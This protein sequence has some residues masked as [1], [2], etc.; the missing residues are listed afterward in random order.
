MMPGPLNRITPRLQP[1]DVQTYNMSLP[2]RSHWH[3]VSCEEYECEFFL[4]G[5]VLTVDISTELGKKQ[6]DYVTHDKTRKYSMQ[7]ESM[8]VFKFVYP[9]GQRGFAGEKHDH[10]MPTGRPHVYT[11]T[12]GDWRGNP[13]QIPRRVHTRPE[14]WVEDFS[15]HQDAIATIVQRG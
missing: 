3:R 5:G 7:R 12:G 14:D 13:R 8:Y 6:Y 4:E 15:I 1:Q 11:V 10:L 2:L 9:P